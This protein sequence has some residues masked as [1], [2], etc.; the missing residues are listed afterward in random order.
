MVAD[1]SAAFMA[2][3]EGHGTFLFG[4][5]MSGSLEEDFQEALSLMLRLRSQAVRFQSWFDP[6]E[7]AV[8]L[9]DPKQLQTATDNT[10]EA[11]TSPNDFPFRITEA[12]VEENWLKLKIGGGLISDGMICRVSQGD[13]RP[14]QLGV[15]ID[16]AGFLRC[17]LDETNQK[18]LETLAAMPTTCG[19]MSE[20][21]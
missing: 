15:K 16:G 13:K 11:T 14:F 20:Q 2:F 17:Q 8:V 10:D 1:L 12:Q 6:D 7:T 19:S 3:D 21:K 18:R 9:R 4:L 5:Q